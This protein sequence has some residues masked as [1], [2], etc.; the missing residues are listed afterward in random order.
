MG[1]IYDQLLKFKNVLG[2]VASNYIFQRDSS[3]TIAHTDIK[4]GLESDS[5]KTSPG[6]EN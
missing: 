3:Q 6:T 5:A 4:N 2:S 1:P